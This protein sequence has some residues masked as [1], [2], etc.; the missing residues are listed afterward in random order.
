[1]KL[2][3]ALTC[4]IAVQNVLS[5]PVADEAGEKKEVPA[6]VP[7]LEKNIDKVQE[8]VHIKDV[9]ETANNSPI[10]ELRNAP[11][12]ATESK[13]DKEPTAQPEKAEEKPLFEKKDE[14]KPD[15]KPAEE[16][17]SELPAKEEKELKSEA[18]EKHE[19]IIEPK[20]CIFYFY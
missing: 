14:K 5:M 6:V 19:V 17:K 11:T 13:K 9:P 8:K 15:E 12:A 18:S 7:L 2:V 1:M 20:V 4:L 16:K 3:I 10:E